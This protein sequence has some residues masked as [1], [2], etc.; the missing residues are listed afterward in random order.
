[1]LRY[2]FLGL[3]LFIG[4]YS[5]GGQCVNPSFT[6]KS[7]ACLN[8]TLEFVNT[9]TEGSNFEWDFCAGDLEQTPLAGNV[10]SNSNFFRA[11]SLRIIED[12]GLWYGFTISATANILMRLDFGNNPNTQ[13]MLNN[14]GNVG[15]VLSSAFAFDVYKENDTWHIL[16]ANGGNRN[17]IRYS[18]VNGLTQ[19]PQTTTLTTPVV[20]ADAGPNAIEI[21]YEAG[22][23]IALVTIGTSVATTK[24]VRLNFGASITN[25]T[26][27][28]SEFTLSSANQLRGIS[29]IKECNTWIGFVAS[30]STNAIY[31]MN[32]GSSLLNTPTSSVIATVNQPVS[33][34]LRTEGA[35]NYVL[36]QNARIEAENAGLF[37]LNFGNSYTT[38][39][40]APERLAF[41]ELTGGGYALDIVSNNSTWHAFTFNLT[42]QNLVR[43]SFPNSCS[44]EQ[45][46]TQSSEES[47]F[48]R[49]SESGIY[50]IVLQYTDNT[51]RVTYTKQNILVSSSNAPSITFNTQNVCED[52]PVNFTSS[53][54]LPIV[55]YNWNFG[56]GNTSTDPNP[57]NT[58]LDDG[59]YNVRLIVTADNACQNLTEQTISIFN[60]P[61]AGFDFLSLPQYCT[62]QQYDFQNASTIDP[63]YPV[64]WQWQI[65]ND[66]VSTDEDLLYTF[67]S[68]ASQEVKLIASIPGCSSETSQT[69]SSLD[70]GP[71][72]DFNFSGQCQD[73]VVQFTNL[74]SGSITSF[75]WNF[76]DGQSSIQT[77]P[78]NT[79]ASTGTFDV[80]LTAFGTSGCNNTQTKT[81]TIYSKPQV[82]FNADL[83]PFSC[84]GSP[85]QFRDLTP[86]PFDSNITQ[87]SWNFDD[88][89]NNTSS[90]K[91]PLHTY[92]TAGSYDVSL[93]VTT[94]FGCQATLQKPI[95]ISPSPQA[96]FTYTPP[97]RN[98]PVQF[99]NTTP[100]SLA[101][102]QWQIGTSNYA[103]PNP[104]HTFTNST[105]YTVNL[106][107]TATNGCI[108][109]VEEIVTVPN[110]LTP[111]FNITRNCIDQETLFTDITNDAADEIEN[112]QWNFAGLGSGLGSPET[113]TFANTGNYNVGMTVTTATGCVYSTVKQVPIVAAPRADFSASPQFGVPPLA[114][115]FLNTSTNATTY[116]WSFN[117]PLN[118]TSTATSPSF[119]FQE[120]GEYQ[121][122]LSAFNAQQC[123]NTIS[124][125]IQAVVPQLDVTLSQLELD[126]T[127]NGGAK[128]SVTIHNKSNVTL[129]SVP[130]LLSISG[131]E[132]REYVEAIIPPNTSYTHTVNF[133]FPQAQGYFCATIEI[134]DGTPADNR[135]CS[136]F[137][138]TAILFNPYPN[139]AIENITVSWIVNNTMPVRIELIHS[140]GKSIKSLE[141]LATSGYNVIDIPLTDIASGLYIV[142]V[143]MTGANT[144]FK[145]FVTD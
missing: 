101:S 79:F 17:I 108:G 57:S 18:F 135:Q 74:S 141:L 60:Q 82:N 86:N 47:I 105:N 38:A 42:S 77:N 76:A 96:S 27:S 80:M 13:P 103:T 43:M 45:P 73:S 120:L 49:Y 126:P 87:W 51:G 1:M 88:D 34:E 122:Q 111:N 54:S 117:D 2:F 39:P 128:P 71:I 116:L 134:D 56:D 50:S 58:F 100:G 4:I 32:F 99:T 89:N 132:I 143:S 67:T 59:E 14:L 9:S 81:V 29:L 92:A 53:A 129:T 112:W 62:N 44:A 69:I 119:T 131:S 84:S 138:P 30:L 6:V 33:V 25:I 31:R 145:V 63:D 68:T 52:A 35:V 115:Q 24:I 8:E 97:C 48:N 127:S 114:V 107:V 12:N 19:L 90:Q 133:E 22:N 94:N 64:T 3:L 70:E 118:T 55:N 66:N 61:I 83:P 121:V 136:T 98:V 102:Q 78:E 137:E 85:T 23:I 125:T 123:V 113:F 65:N 93:T 109:F 91:N 106:A 75:D 10:L 7:S 124:K 142:R 72:T 130:L 37:R 36:I 41:P 95:T 40:P 139:P 21:Q 15:S 26:P 144:A 46:I 20:F 16:V 110:V 28:L 11:R 104:I 5:A 140:S